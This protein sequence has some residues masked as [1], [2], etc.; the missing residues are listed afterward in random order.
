MANVMSE[1][2][3]EQTPN[4]DEIEWPEPDEGDEDLDPLFDS[5][6][7]YVEQIDHYKEHQ[8]KPTERRAYASRPERLKFGRR[9]VTDRSQIRKGV[10]SQQQRD[11][12]GRFRGRK[13]K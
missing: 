4:L 10:K 5:T 3:D 1:S 13:P 7:D 12:G 8:G 6:R 11:H 9:H 2:L